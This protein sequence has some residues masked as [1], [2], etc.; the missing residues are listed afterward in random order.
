MA[1]VRSLEEPLNPA[2]APVARDAGRALLVGLNREQ[3]QAVTHEHGPALV[4]AGPGTGKTE[5][6][7]R[8]VA[9]LIA[10]KL[11]RPREILALTFTDNA[12]QEMQARVDVLV[13]YGQADA[14]IHTFHAFGDRLLREHAFELGLPAEPKLLRRAELTVLLR[15]HL[16]ELGLERYA[17]LGDPTRFLGALVDLFGRAKDEDI[18]PAALADH[19]TGLQQRASASDEERA[20]LADLIVARTELA[21]AYQRYVELLIANG[22]IDHADQ[23]GLCLRLLRERPAVQRAVSERYRFVLV[24]ELQDTNRAQLELVLSLA[25]VNRNV[26]A[27]GDPEQGIYA[28]RGARTGNIQRFAEGL[29]SVRSI[30]L[31]RNYRSLAPIIDAARRISQVAGAAVPAR[32][33]QVAHRRQRGAAVRHIGFAT[34]DDEADGVA[35]QIEGRI[36]SGEPASRFCVLVRSN[37]EIDGFARSLRVRGVAVDT[38]ARRRLIDVP[39][40]RS[41]VAFL[42]V[43]A[44]PADSIELYALAAAPPYGLAGDVL[45]TLL[46][47]SRRR[48]RSLWEALRDAVAASDQRLGQDSLQAAR[49]LVAHVEAAIKLS[50]DRPS[51]EVLYDYLRRSGRLAALARA[52]VDPAEAT[53]IGRLCEIVRARAALLAHDRVCFLAAYLTAG[54]LG[55]E[56][57]DSIAE[58]EAVR[59]LTVHRAK[60]LEFGAVFVCGL[61]DGRFPVRSRP[62]TLTLPQ[63]LLGGEP[64][65]EAALAEERRLFYVAITRARDEVLLTSHATGPRGRGRRRPSVFIAEALD[66]PPA[67]TAPSAVRETTDLAYVL[68]DPTPAA[69]P[70]SSERGPLSLSYSQLDEYLGCPERYRLRYEIGIPTMPHHALSYGTAVHGAIAAFHGSQ[71]RGEPLSADELTAE[72]RRNWQ[73]DGFVSREHEDARFTAGQAALERFRVQQLASGSR[74]VAVEKPF[75]F[76]FGT[77]EIRGRIDRLDETPAG[78]VITDYKSSDVRDQ[79]RADSRARDSLQLQVYAL[80]HQAETGTLPAALQL[81]FVESGV[82]GKTAPSVERLDKAQDQMFHAADGIRAGNFSPKPSPITCGYCPFRAVCTA[83]AA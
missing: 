53:A 26:M 41:L 65:D 55:D 83:S 33:E 5:V 74:P 59:V 20:A 77:D 12:A 82:I 63:E 31:R 56:E 75:V 72:L 42:R 54:D 39:G 58:T 29:G 38:G 7:T 51:G 13:P 67:A 44:D 64:T 66:Q 79:K 25:G 36:R 47:A 6:I 11:A 32:T 81:H 48:S 10:T 21:T 71:T 50:S 52:D 17:P 4:V 27:V 43:A 57:A 30:V 9:W 68:V 60:G 80:A 76:R 49:S 16:F 40:V 37:S 23:V 28:F 34:P 24:D 78:P 46:G 73:P 45:A 1:L 61:V 3:R 62:A 35:S 8:R 15:E 19:A 18:G 14:A 2:A 69:P 70:A 22:A